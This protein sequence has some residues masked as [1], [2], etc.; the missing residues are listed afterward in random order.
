MQQIPTSAPDN[1][2]FSMIIVDDTQFSRRFI[3]KNC[4]NILEASGLDYSIAIIDNGDDGWKRCEGKKFHYYVIDQEMPPGMNGIEVCRKVL[5]NDP[6]ARVVLYTAA[7]SKVLNKEK[8]PKEVE[9]IP[10]DMGMLKKSL[11]RR[12]EDFRM[13]STAN[14]KNSAEGTPD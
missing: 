12:V 1:T 11:V 3:E 8:I 9:V 13:E 5:Q 14:R 2:L 10:K 6:R 4:S 7:S